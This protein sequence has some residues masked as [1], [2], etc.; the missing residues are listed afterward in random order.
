M[1]PSS[2]LPS[3]P[4]LAPL[5]LA[6]AEASAA[7]LFTLS[8]AD[9]AALMQTAREAGCCVRHIELQGCHDKAGL[10]AR[11][12]QALNFPAC[13]G[14]N[15]DALSD[16]LGDLDWL[17]PSK[18]YVLVFDGLEPPGQ[19]PILL[20]VLAHTAEHWRQEKV[21]FWALIVLPGEELEKA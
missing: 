4:Q 9:T 19:W 15:W 12:A 17:P 7:G 14:H 13:F 16:C 5:P 3:L 2:Q 6:F 8:A 1:S 20:E 21:P 18:G 11:I 10:L